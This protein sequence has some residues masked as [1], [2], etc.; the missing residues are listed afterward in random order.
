MSGIEEVI[1]FVVEIDVNKKMLAIESL[2][3]NTR[4]EFPA[5]DLPVL[6]AALLSFDPQCLLPEKPCCNL[7]G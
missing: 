4:L 1:P 5:A 7:S 6:T 3:T 2:R